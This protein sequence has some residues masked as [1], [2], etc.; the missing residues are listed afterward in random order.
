MNV[1]VIILFYLTFGEF[2]HNSFNLIMTS[3]R[4]IGVLVLSSIQ[5]KLRL[6]ISLVADFTLRVLYVLYPLTKGLGERSLPQPGI[7][8]LFNV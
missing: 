2:F 7:E 3:W 6:E 4:R 1:F 5:S 8:T